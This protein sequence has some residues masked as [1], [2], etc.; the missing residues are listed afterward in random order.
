MTVVLSHRIHVLSRKEE[1]GTVALAGK[2]VIV[3]DILFAT[4]TMTVAL[5]HG[6]TMVI[7]TMDEASARDESARHPRGSFVL[8]GELYAN[9][10]EGFTAPTP[11][12]LL[13]HGVRDKKLILATTN[14]TVAVKESAAADHLY[15][16]SLLN[17]AA[18]VSH[19]LAKH[20][21]N[22]IV[23]VC[24]GSMGNFNFEDYYGAG[25]LVDLFIKSLGQDID[26]SD[27]ARASRAVFSSG[28]PVDMLSNCRVGR[29]MTGRGHA[30]E[31]D[32]AAQLSSLQ[33]VPRLENGVIILS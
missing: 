15:V 16:A 21:T 23:I 18:M 8:A 14:G 4:T 26:V 29:I 20:P 11:L 6:A 10:F 1:L 7:P 28:K 5:A 33:V 12:A 13:D 2:V 32:Y 9:V 19:V 25:Y 3:L 24:S 22:P 31:I 30:R 27:A 17:G